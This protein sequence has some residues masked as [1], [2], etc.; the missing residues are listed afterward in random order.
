VGI[1]ENGGFESRV[2]VLE[3]VKIR[4]RD[5]EA[6]ALEAGQA[7]RE[8]AERAG[9]F[10]GLVFGLDLIEGSLLKMKAPPIAT[11]R[12]D[13]MRAVFGRRNEPQMATLG[14]VRALPFE[15]SALAATNPP[16]VVHER[17]GV[18]KHPGVDPLEDVASG[19]R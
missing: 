14:V 18:S 8:A 16:Q 13:P 17:Y 4:N 5:G 9:C 2:T 19:S 10:V 7:G 12:I 11:L 1:C 3:I 6:R 15:F